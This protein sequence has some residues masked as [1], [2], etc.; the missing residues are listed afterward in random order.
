MVGLV[1]CLVKTEESFE[2]VQGG[3]VTKIREGTEDSGICSKEIRT[4]SIFP[5]VLCDPL[6]HRS[7]I[8]N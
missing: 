4:R 2:E 8:T 5:L 6:G 7:E 1:L 3:S